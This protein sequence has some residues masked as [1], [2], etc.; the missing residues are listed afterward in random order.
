LWQRRTS[1]PLKDKTVQ[2]LA[3]EDLLIILCVHGSK[4]AWEQLKWVCDVA[5]LLR[6]HD[7]LDWQQ[8][9]ATAS[10]WR[11]ER[12]VLLGLSLAQQLLDAPLPVLASAHLSADSDVQALSL[13]MPLSLLADQRAGVDEKQ[14]VALY[15][16]L[17]D[18]WWER[19]WLGLLLCRAQS[20]VVATPPPWF[21]WRTSLRHLGRLVRPLH[22]T[23]RGLPSMTI[24][25][26]ISRWVEHVG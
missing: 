21:R 7:R 10:T 2:G 18:S 23:M 8:V 16:F 3:P 19:W 15:F 4:H 11:C 25:R 6:A 5:E 1:I 20:P 26:A 12:M 13:R 14:A 17:K 24:R 22:R 9:F